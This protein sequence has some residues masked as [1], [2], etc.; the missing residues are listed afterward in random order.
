[1]DRTIHTG[2]HMPDF[3]RLTKVLQVRFGGEWVIMLRLHPQLTAR[4][5]TADSNDGRIID[6]SRIDDMYE[7]LAASDAFLTDYSSAAFDAMV[8]HIPIFL[9][10]DD[11]SEYENER[12]S[13]L[14]DLKKLPFPF[15]EDDDELQKVIEQFDMDRYEDVIVDFLNT[16]GVLEDGNAARRVCDEIER[17]Q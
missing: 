7:V 15:A 3:L 14:W 5:I 8:M 11:Y 17:M 6:V 13:L 4:N 2:D 10:C 12:G 9:Y 1:M 16:E